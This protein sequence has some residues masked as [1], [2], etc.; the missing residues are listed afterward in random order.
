MTEA[1]LTEENGAWRALL[2]ESA[3]TTTR[4][5]DETHRIA[6]IGIKT[7]PSDGPSYTVPEYMQHAGYEIVP[8]PVYFPAITEILG[9][10]VHR[11]LATVEPPADL[12]LLFRR[13]ADLPQHVDEILAA[14]PRVV[15]MQL[16]I[17][18][19]HVAEQFARAGIRVLQNKCFQVELRRRGR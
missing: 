15:W 7:Q 9:A 13:S 6:V 10:P 11:S 2:D 8:V 12:V 14:K 4:I 5:L 17:G 19:E 18:H 1:K 16:G 3:E